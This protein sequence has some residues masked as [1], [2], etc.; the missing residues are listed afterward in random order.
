MSNAVLCI[1]DKGKKKNSK[2][3]KKKEEKKNSKVK[4]TVILCTEL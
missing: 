4:N 1:N 3:K 2:V